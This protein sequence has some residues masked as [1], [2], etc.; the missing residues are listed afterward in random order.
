MKLLHQWNKQRRFH[1][2][3]RE[4]Q[5]F[6]RASL[7][8]VGPSLEV[9][10]LVQETFV[11]A[12]RGWDKFEG[13]S[14]ARTWLYRIAMNVAKDHFR[15]IKNEEKFEE[16]E[17]VTENTEDDQNQIRDLRDALKLLSFEQ[18]EALVLS[19]YWGYTIAEIAHL[20]GRPEGTIKSQIYHAKIKLEKEL[21]GGDQK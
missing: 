8:W 11:K 17:I 2:L 7:F 13:F 19:Y 21:K 10:D 16:R 14:K 5:A 9:D 6:I 12:W 15:K 4:H 3:Y 1:E 20:V 18:R